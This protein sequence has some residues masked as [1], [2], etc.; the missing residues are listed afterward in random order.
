MTPTL[1]SVIS[2]MASTEFTVVAMLLLLSACET[3][4]PYVGYTH[5]SD[6][7]V[8]G[9]G[10]DLVCVGLKTEKVVEVS[11]SYCENLNNDWSGVKIDVDYVWRKK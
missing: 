7:D 6:P 8:P 3:P 9:D 2:A 4:S 1:K 10:Y 11:A 5:L